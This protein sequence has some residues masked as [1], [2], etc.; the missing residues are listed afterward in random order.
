MTTIRSFSTLLSFGAALAFAGGCSSGDGHDPAG[1][2][3]DHSTAA[4]DLKKQDGT[5]EPKP[6][7]E[8]SKDKM[9][10]GLM[11]MDVTCPVSKDQAV[12]EI[13]SEHNGKKVYFC[14]KGCIDDF[15]K[16]PKKYGF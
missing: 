2:G 10:E 6:T 13:S 9:S 15:K 4:A 7:G 8:K 16:E 12:Q 3:H 1:G 5:Y 14:C 11:L